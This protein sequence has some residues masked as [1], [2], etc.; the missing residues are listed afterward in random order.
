M[1]RTKHNSSNRRNLVEFGTSHKKVSAESPAALGSVKM[2]VGSTHEKEWKKKWA[3]TMDTLL[4][5]RLT[6][7][8]VARLFSLC[9]YRL[10][11]LEPNFA[12]LRDNREK[13]LKKLQLNKFHNFPSSHTK[14]STFFLA[15]SKVDFDITD[16]GLTTDDFSWK[17][18]VKKKISGQLCRLCRRFKDN[19]FPYKRSKLC[20][21]CTV[22]EKK[23]RERRNLPASCNCTN[24]NHNEVR[25]V[26]AVKV[27]QQ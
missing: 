3:D 8:N 23:G 26:P 21:L 24:D 25:Q 11:K 19:I 20:H 12:R 13:S 2:R 27:K 22:C 17:D 7:L 5:G 1:F 6:L 15:R 4:A 16:N 18:D 14:K 10:G 9:C